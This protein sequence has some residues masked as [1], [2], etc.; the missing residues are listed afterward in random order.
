MPPHITVGQFNE[1]YKPIMDGVGLCAENY[2]RWIHEKHGTAYAVVPRVPGYEDDDPY[3]VIR[4]PSLPVPRMAPYRFGVPWAS[5]TLGRRL[6]SIPFDIVHSH[7]PFV[8]GRMARRTAGSR[9]IPHVSTFH[10]K[11]RDD[12]TRFTTVAPAVHAFVNGLVRFYNSCDHVWTPSDATKRTLREYGYEG[13]ITVV[14]NGSDLRRPSAE[15]RARYRA[16]GESLCG[17]P[18]DAFVFL[19]VGQH[20]WEKNVELILRSIALLVGEELRGPVALVFAGEGYA[21]QDMKRM[22]CELGIGDRTVFLGKIVE[23]ERLKAV[24][25]RADLFLFP[26]VYDNAPLVMREAAAFGVPTVVAEGSSAAEAIREDENGFAVPVDAEAMAARLKRLVENRDLV[27]R[28]GTNAS[29]SVYRSWEDIVD[30]VA[31]EYERIIVR[32]R[33]SVSQ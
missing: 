30:W 10:T 2:A 9:G 5:P 8:A 7:S 24:Y 22:A 20:R 15:E 18:H 25:A 33:R 28:V 11:Y 23:R 4:Y 6:R 29:L 19:F 12:F 14:P 27:S 13:E 21:A 16:E 1:S 3:T 26:S 31:G 17:V 32:H